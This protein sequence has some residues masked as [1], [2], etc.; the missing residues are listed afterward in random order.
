MENGGANVLNGRYE[1]NINEK[2]RLF[3]PSKMRD[4]LGSKF[5]LSKSP[6]DICLVIYP[7]EKWEK[8]LEKLETNSTA[9][10]A[11]RRRL[12][13]N[14]VDMETD[15]QG[16]IIIPQSLREFANLDGDVTIIGT[17]DSV[18]IWNAAAYAEYE[19]NEDNE[20]MTELLIEY[21]L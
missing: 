3:V 13:G 12:F 16:R 9:T 10:K 17:G 19:Q 15:K 11:V 8:I 1:Y 6:T 20:A 21:G 5:I 14:A 4:N 2:G 7:L 18:E